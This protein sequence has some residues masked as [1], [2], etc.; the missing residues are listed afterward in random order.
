MG[1]LRLNAGAMTPPP[2]APYRATGNEPGWM[3]SATGPNFEF[4]QM[5][6]ETLRGTL[7]AATWA[8]GAAVWQIAD[9]GLTVRMAPT[10]CRDNM[11]GMPF[12]ESVTLDTAD[13]PRSGCGGDPQTL[14]TGGEWL[15]EDV[16]GAGIID[17]AQ[18]T[19]TFDPNG[20]VYGSGGCNRYNGAFT[21]TG[22]GFGFGP[23]AAT[24]M[25]CEEPKMTLES[26]FF[27]AMASVIRFDIAETGAL[28]L[29]AADG[30]PVIRASKS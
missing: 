14:L 13:G 6:A 11:T 10:L 4:A 17:N 12:P 23:A 8:D 29:Y 21:L 30:K 2:P 28:I 9:A 15:V 27:Q 26:A 5:G 24:M 18:V 3:F 1:E 16:G 25:A 20:S 22:E 7:P 19:M